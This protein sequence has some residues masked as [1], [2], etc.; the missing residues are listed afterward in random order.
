MEAKMNYTIIMVAVK[1]E[2]LKRISRSSG[3]VKKK[4]YKGNPIGCT[5]GSTIFL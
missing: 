1:K 3:N 5:F 4:I 2:I